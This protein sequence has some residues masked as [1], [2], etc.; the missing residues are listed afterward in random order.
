M[1]GDEKLE[2]ASGPVNGSNQ[3]FSTSAPYT[4]GT[5]FALLNGQLWPGDDDEGVEEL[6]PGTGTFR[7]R[8]APRQ[9][10]RVLVRYIEA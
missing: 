8:L 10:D 2:E 4:S 6:D 1:T 5:L 7:L 9:N 3:F